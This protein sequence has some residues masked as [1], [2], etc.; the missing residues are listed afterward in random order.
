MISKSGL[1]GVISP[2]FSMPTMVGISGSWL[3]SFLFKGFDITFNSGMDIGIVLGD[4]D[5]RS[6]ID[7]PLVYHRLGIYYNNWGL[8]TGLDIQKNIG[9]NISILGDCDLRWLPGLDGSYSLEHKLLISWNKSDNFRLMTGYKFVMGE[10]P[11][12]SDMRLLPYVPMAESWVPMIELQWAR[13][14]K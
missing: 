3:A 10:F 6:S 13:N 14:R 11:Y 7:L 4:L 2:D 8:K 12:G 5:S 1:G 9:T